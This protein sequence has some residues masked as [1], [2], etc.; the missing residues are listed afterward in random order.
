MPGRRAP[1]PRRYAQAL[2]QLALEQGTVDRWRQDIQ[3][4]TD[5][6]RSQGVINLLESPGLRPEDRLA[7]VR[8]VL[9]N[10]SQQAANFMALLA[11]HR[12]LSKLP[13]IQESLQ[14]QLDEHEGIMRA[15]A[16]TAVPLSPSE[17]DSLSRQLQQRWG[18]RVVLETRV[19]Q[20]ILGGIV[21]RAGD[22]VL[23]GSV[24]GRLQQMKRTL[25]TRA[26]G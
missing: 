6:A 8:R 19:D 5:V 4:L 20:S 16:T 21:V 10:V 2:F 17:E 9:P 12:A 3:T 25:L 23:D 13:R 7:T 14:A 1:T 26:N 15:V 11:E 24:R 22:Q 18:K